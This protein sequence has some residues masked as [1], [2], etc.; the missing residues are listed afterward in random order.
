M[1]PGTSGRLVGGLCGDILD[2]DPCGAEASGLG[3]NGGTVSLATAGIGIEPLGG[4]TRVLGG[5]DGI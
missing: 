4:K 5:R 2:A 1:G 3:G